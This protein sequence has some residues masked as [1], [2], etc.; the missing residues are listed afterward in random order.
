MIILDS[1]KYT[2]RIMVIR[3]NVEVVGILAVESGSLSITA[4]FWNRTD[5]RNGRFPAFF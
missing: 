5:A 4:K 1:D 2:A 3:W